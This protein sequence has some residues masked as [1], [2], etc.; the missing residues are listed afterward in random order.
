MHPKFCGLVAIVVA[1]SGC[2]LWPKSGSSKDAP[3]AAAPSETYH[4]DRPKSFTNT[5]GVSVP[6]NLMLLC[7]YRVGKTLAEQDEKNRQ[8]TTPQRLEYGT[9]ASAPLKACLSA[10]GYLER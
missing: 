2:S 6:E 4:S 9:G 5:A 10:Y 3:K 1:L 7:Q 8:S